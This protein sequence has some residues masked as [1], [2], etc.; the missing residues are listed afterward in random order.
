MGFKFQTKHQISVDRKRDKSKINLER[1]TG[2][3]NK[4]GTKRGTQNKFG[5]KNRPQNKLCPPI[6]SKNLIER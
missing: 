5:T 3:K 6:K 4:F 2:R 1:K